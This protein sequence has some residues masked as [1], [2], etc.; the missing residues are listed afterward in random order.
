M[1]LVIT[2]DEMR[3]FRPISKGIDAGRIQ[4]YIQEAQQFDLKRLLGDPL[5]V[6]FMAK[7]DVAGDPQYA[8]YQTL[9]KGTSYTY[10]NTSI[11]HPGLI[12]Y[13]SY[14]AL[15]R[16]FNNNQVNAVKY[17]LVVKETDQSTPIDWKVIAAS[18]SEL[19]SNALALQAD[20]QKYLRY[21]P[22]LY[23]LYQYN[24]G[25]ASG[26]TGPR[27][28]DPDDVNGGSRPGDRT[29]ISW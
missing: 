25:S 27:F 19:R 18:V 12:G 14:H 2:L 29:L 5:Y 3:E 23:P 22:A 24:D 15:A 28:F 20:I 4:P 1:K 8:N 26:Q 6:D 21:N 13:L 10:N 11:E 9:L 17:G 7:F 16:F